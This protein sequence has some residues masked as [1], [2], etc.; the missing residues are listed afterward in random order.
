MRDEV[1][2]EG[3]A[4]TGYEPVREVFA[5]QLRQQATG[6][7]AFSACVDGEMVIDLYGGVRNSAG[8]S[9]TE[10]T[11][12]TIFSGTKGL[13]ATC[14]AILADRGA[15]DIEA[16]VSTYW[17]EFSGAGKERIA[18]ADVMSHRAGLPVIERP[19][20]LAALLDDQTMA[21]H[22]AQ[23]KPLWPAG[24]TAYHPLTYGW[25]A[26]ELVRRITGV[27]IGQF[28]QAEVA[29]RLNLDTWIGAPAEIEPRIATLTLA[30][31]FRARW[32]EAIQVPLFAASFGT[33]EIFEE[34]LLWN[35][36]AAHRSE[37]PGANGISSAHS[38]A[39]LYERLLTHR[40]D[41]A[42]VSDRTRAMCVAQRSR[43]IDRITGDP[44]AFGIGFELQT[45]LGWLGPARDAFGH[46][47][48]GGSAHGAWPTLRTGFSYVTNTLVGDDVD[49]RAR[50]L[51][52]SLYSLVASRGR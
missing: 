14:V 26:G 36:P 22:L 49:N 37:M 29:H 18:V 42:L 5:A 3:S 39:R 13:V 24:E 43:G 30:D 45:E 17:P 41:E 1:A 6:G 10:D 52:A 23:Q 32:R 44:L 46:C 16:P 20:T 31:S 38:M 48:A 12:A 15:I 33:E 21:G 11:V 8:A 35:T 40:G 34:P 9:W 19:D 2:F 25:L 51:L 28:F 50:A 4:S 47:G 27:S 7:A